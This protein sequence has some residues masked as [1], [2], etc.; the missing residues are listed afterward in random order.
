MMISVEAKRNKRLGAR[1][2][3]EEK[4]EGAHG[5]DSMTVST[6]LL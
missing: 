4:E 1:Q 6:D 3:G 2:E 5:C